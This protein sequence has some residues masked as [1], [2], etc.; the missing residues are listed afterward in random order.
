MLEKEYNKNIEEYQKNNCLDYILNN[1]HDY[2]FVNGD[3]DKIK[4]TIK[5][6]KNTFNNYFIY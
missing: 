1:Y 3:Y 5:K 2:D 4:K 6:H